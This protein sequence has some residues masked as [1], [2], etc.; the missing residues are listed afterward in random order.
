MA[1]LNMGELGIGVAPIGQY[2]IN[3]DR[4]ASTGNIFNNDTTLNNI[5]IRNGFSQYQNALS[6]TLYG[7][8]IQGAGT[9]APTTQETFGLTFFTRPMLN[10]S[11]YNLRADRTLAIMDNDNPYTVARYVKS[12]LDP[13]GNDETNM[14]PLVDPLNPFIPI[15]SNNL[16]SLAGWRD[17]ITDYYQSPAG[18]KKEQWAMVDSTNKVFGTYELSAT[19]RNVRGNFLYYLFHV[20]QTYMSLVYEGVI[21]PYPHFVVKNTIDYQTRIW[22]LI[23]DPT[24]TYVEEIISCNNAFPLSN[25]LGIRANK[26]ENEHINREIDTINLS[27]LCQ[28]ANYFDP[29]QMYEFNNTVYALNPLFAKKASRKKYFR[30]LNPAEYKIFSYRA[31]PR[32]NTRTARLEWWVTKAM[33]QTLL[34]RVDYPSYDEYFIDVRGRM[35]AKL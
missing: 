1:D 32:I 33:H 14:C 34:G 17:P 9:P 12:I 18:L 5:L 10:L 28:G 27:F 8:D 21:D 35:E 16:N 15:L 25:P 31:Y 7:L 22:R 26:S 19:F 2:D 29:L 20:W 11:Y 13:I 23:L 30:M 4:L 3:P 6:S 24:K